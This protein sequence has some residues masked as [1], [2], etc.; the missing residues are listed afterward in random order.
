MKKEAK[1]ES[2]FYRKVVFI[3]CDN[4]GMNLHPQHLRNSES[5]QLNLTNEHTLHQHR[6]H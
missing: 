2:T 5:Q 6:R 1:S 4:T 3:N